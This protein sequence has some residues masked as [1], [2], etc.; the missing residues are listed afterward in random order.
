MS[1]ITTLAV[2]INVNVSDETALKCLNVLNMYL[3]GNKGMRLRET[4]KNTINENNNLF[5]YYS[6]EIDESFRSF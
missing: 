1:R 5:D 3:E 4:K 6:Y 2:D